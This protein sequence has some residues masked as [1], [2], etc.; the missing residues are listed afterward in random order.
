MKNVIQLVILTLSLLLV[1]AHDNRQYCNNL[2]QNFTDNCTPS[3]LTIKGCCELK[4]FSPTY[5]SSGVYKMSK[6]SFDNSVNVYCDMTTDGGGWI[7]IQRNKKNSTVNFNR[8]WT[9][10]GLLE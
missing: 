8:N 4:I 5:A 10:E 3:M 7:V 2:Y 1:N 6:G 9:V